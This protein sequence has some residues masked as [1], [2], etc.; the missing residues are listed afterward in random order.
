MTGLAL[1]WRLARREMRAGFSGFRILLA[2]LTIGVG[3][4]TAIGTTSESMVAGLSA[5]ARDLLG[6]DI[7]LRLHSQPPNAEQLAYVQAH[8]LATSSVVEMKAMAQRI[9]QRSGVRNQLLVE[10]KGVDQAY[11]LSGA[12][13]LDPP[14]AQDQAFANEK[15]VWGAAVEKSMLEKMGLS[16]GDKI[17]LGDATFVLRARI[18]HEPDRVA[19]VLSFGPRLIVSQNALA[20][21]Q[22]VQPGSRVHYHLRTLLAKNA[23][24]EAWKKDLNEAFPKA[25]W[26]VRGVDQA[27]PG[28]QR[29]FEHLYLFLSF[30]ALTALLAG[31]IG[32]SNATSAYLDKKVTDIATLKCLGAPNSL[33]FACYFFQIMALAIFGIL[34]GLVC[35]AVLPVIAIW[36]AEAAGLDQMISAMPKAGFY[37]KPLLTAAAFGLLTAA[38]FA[39][40]PLGQ[41]RNVPAAALFRQHIET[42]S[43]SLSPY[44]LAGLSIGVLS[45]S[46]LIIFDSSDT[47]FAYWFIAGA[48]LSAL[49]LR[50]GSFLLKRFAL[51]LGGNVKTPLK[52]AGWRLALANIYRPGTSTTGVITSLGLGLSVMVA[53]SLIENNLGRQVDERLPRDAPAFFFIDIQP[54]QVAAFDQTIA[55]DARAH[56]FRRVPTMRGRIIAINDVPVEKAKIHPDS[57]WAIH[58]DRAL[59]FAADKP[60]DSLIVAGQWWPENYDGPPTISLD[61]GIARG[62]G[63]GLGDRLTISVMGRSISPVIASLREIDWR[64]LR[65]DFAII[66]APGTLE[67]APHTHIAAVQAPVEAEEAIESA[68][69]KGFPNITTVRVR[70]ALENAGR[71]LSGIG[72]AIRATASLAIL[73]GALVLAGSIAAAARRRVFESVVFKVLGATRKRILTTYLMEYGLLGLT[74]GLAA[75]AIGTL[76]AWA[77]VVHLMHTDWVFQPK[78]AALSLGSAIVLTLVAGF[79]ASWRAMGRKAAPYLRNE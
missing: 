19:G 63:I 20:K 54:N 18:T 69:A 27:T 66:F 16:L 33:V 72:T 39:L 41:T 59:T 21:T 49:L 62:F 42:K 14:I 4:I 71:I 2:C 61:A 1:S 51:R 28:V 78:I 37:L 55:K 15:G 64:S 43:L 46:A 6:G 31:G 56:G 44:H 9:D 50:A 10:L 74:A 67:G 7:D 52:S 30:V 73:A 8:S 13:K 26:R 24:A 22:L 17:H 70:D 47:S 65:F 53:I 34:L 12:L 77:V 68:I 60:K 36:A 48:V 32:V 29:F 5:N 76:V 23:E 45:L 11:P 79:A 3:A 35:G 25:P 75:S 58:G 38:T 40:W 57:A